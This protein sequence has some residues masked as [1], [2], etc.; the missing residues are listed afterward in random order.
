MTRSHFLLLLVAVPLLAPSCARPER[1]HE[2]PAVAAHAPAASPP[3]PVASVPADAHA[4]HSGPVKAPSLADQKP[5]NYAGLHNVVAYADELY[6]GS[7]P[8]GVEGFETLKAMGVKTIISVDGA[9]PDVDN[10]TRHGMRY[11]H[12]PIGYNG[13]SHE[14]TLEIAKACKE[15]PGPIYLHCHHGKHRSAGALGAAVVT[16][17]LATNDEATARMKVSGTAPNYVGLYKCTAVASPVDP[18]VLASLP[19]NFP[20]RSLPNGLVGSMTAIDEAN[21]ELKAIEKA[22]WSVPA[23]HAD[24]VPAAIAGRMADL[25]RTAT[26]DVASKARSREFHDAM[27]AASKEIADL[28]QGLVAGMSPEDLGKRFKAVQQSCKDCHAKHRD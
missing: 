24:L 3:A 28:E 8:E 25:F 15:L 18:K 19:P 23:D 4:E 2:A 1:A 9:L 14:R 5:A 10:A 27:L 12:L 26:E 11:V 16:L 6:S 20:E 17:G 22:S 7:V 21:D 13:M